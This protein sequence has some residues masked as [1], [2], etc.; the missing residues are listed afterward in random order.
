MGSLIFYTMLLAGLCFEPILLLVFRY[1]TMYILLRSM[2]TRASVAKASAV[3]HLTV[4]CCC[5]ITMMVI[6]S[7][8]VTQTVGNVLC[9]STLLHLFTDSL[10]SNTPVIAADIM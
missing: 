5:C 10:A 1:P 2:S 8:Q 9:Y 7:Y 3:V 4:P 6:L